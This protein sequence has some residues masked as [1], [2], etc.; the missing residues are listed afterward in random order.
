MGSFH[1][2]VSVWYTLF[3][4]PLLSMQKAGFRLDRF[5]STLA[6]ESH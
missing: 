6:T 3:D 2:S 1:V 5:A 4:H